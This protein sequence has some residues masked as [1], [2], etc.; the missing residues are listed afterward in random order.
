MNN[1]VDMKTPGVYAVEYTVSD[2]AG[3]WS[4]YS[5]LIVVVEG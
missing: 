1:T 5:K 2:A 3:D 4:A